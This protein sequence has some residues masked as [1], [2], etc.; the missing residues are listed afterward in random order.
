LF[1]RQFDARLGKRPVRR[2]LRRSSA[3]L[4]RTDRVTVAGRWLVADGTIAGLDLGALQAAHHARRGVSG[5]A[6]GNFWAIAV[7]PL[8]SRSREQCNWYA[9]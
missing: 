5:P 2:W 4:N 7:A 3:A 1:F 6:D 8:H 9:T